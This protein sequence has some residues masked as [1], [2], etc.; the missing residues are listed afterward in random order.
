MTEQHKN[1]WDVFGRHTSA[2]GEL[3]R[4]YNGDFG[5]KRIGQDY[6]IRNLKRF[7][8]LKT[9]NQDKPKWYSQ[10]IF[11]N[12]YVTKNINA[13][14]YPFFQYRIR[15][16]LFYFNSKIQGQSSQISQQIYNFNGGRERL[17]TYTSK[18]G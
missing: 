13:A 7:E 2:G 18:T 6:S 9:Q 17:K 12:D 10:K 14:M 4:I 15:S 11:Y 8:A 16:C 3:F 5:G 1:I